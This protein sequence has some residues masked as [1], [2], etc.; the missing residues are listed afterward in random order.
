MRWARLTGVVALVAALAPSLARAGRADENVILDE[1]AYWRCW[2]HGG[3]LR[4]DYEAM[5]ADGQKVLDKR[6][7]ERLRQTVLRKLKAEGR[8]TDDWRKEVHYPG[9]YLNL[10]LL[11]EVTTTPP[12][13]TWMQASFDD[14]DWSCYRKPF[15][16]GKDFHL[17]GYVDHFFQ[18]KTTCF[19]TAFEAS[20]TAARSRGG[21]CRPERWR[22][23]H[24]PS[25]TP[26]RPTT[27]AGASIRP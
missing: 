17:D 8:A 26:P 5:K 24:R 16:M 14:G 18:I 6:S 13:A 21:T 9:R 25:R 2:L 23:T 11:N 1:R 27:P 4:I 20:S 3:A 19:R 7:F 22:T 10:R 12:P 15:K